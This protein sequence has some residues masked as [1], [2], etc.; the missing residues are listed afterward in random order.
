MEK[1]EITPTVAPATNIGPL[2]KK[3]AKIV[4]AMKNVQKKGFNSFHKYAYVQEADLTEAVRDLLADTGV[5][6]FASVAE[7]KKE[8]TLTT[9]MMEFTFAD[10]DTGA[11]F[12]VRVPGC[13]DDKADKGVYKALTGAVKYFLMK[14]FLISTNDDPEADIETDKRAASPTKAAAKPKAAAASGPAGAVGEYQARYYGVQEF[15]KKDKS[16]KYKAHRF[17]IKLDD[18]ST[19]DVREFTGKD[20][21]TQEDVLADI[22]FTGVVEDETLDKGIPC[23]ASA[24]RE[25]KFLKIDGWSPRAA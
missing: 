7:M 5:F 10:G 6:I 12:T 15:D 14:N 25:G 24:H 23:T 11:S 19:E 20:K 8:G 4:G 21:A 1:E 13:G 2:V 3:L 16:G 17:V 9:V 22:G 18:G